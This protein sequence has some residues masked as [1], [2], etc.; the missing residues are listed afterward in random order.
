MSVMLWRA[1][2]MQS[3][4]LRA[5]WTRGLLRWYA[6]NGRHDLPWRQTDDPWLI[7]L[8]E[9]M[10]QQTQVARVLPKWRAFAERWP[11]AAAFAAAPRAEVLRAWQGLGYPRRAVALH[12][13][14]VAV[15]A[16]WPREE[17]A[18]RA[19]PGIGE[20]TARALLTIAFDAPGAPP[21]DVNIRRVAARAALGVEPAQAAAGALRSALTQGRPRGLSPRTY[22]YALFDVGALHCR[23][24]PR[25]GGCPLASLCPTRAN[26]RLPPRAPRVQPRYGG[27][28][29]ELRGR[30]LAA[31]LDGVA[32]D[33][34]ETLHA[35]CRGCAAAA[36]PGAIAAALQGLARD[37]LLAAAGS[38]GPGVAPS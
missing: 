38:S 31:L 16:G 7:L 5:V 20:Y 1:T 14:A 27:S 10:L 6:A 4:K 30:L 25:C 32:P 29:R 24:L 22:T 12:R 8:S 26:P 11:T 3:D 37:G 34:Q 17:R 18:L 13:T 33:D 36:R 15:A 9:V 35:R 19:L 2:A 28:M 23:A 21:C